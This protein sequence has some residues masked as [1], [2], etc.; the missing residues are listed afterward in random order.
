MIVF[1]HG[2]LQFPQR[3][4]RPEPDRKWWESCEKRARGDRMLSDA[5]IVKSRENGYSHSAGEKENCRTSDARELEQQKSLSLS[6]FLRVPEPSPPL[7]GAGTPPL[8][9]PR[10]CS[11]NRDVLALE[12]RVRVLHH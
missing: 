4:S 8:T 11:S 3:S 10:L 9:S 5:L 1:F 7:I 2:R 12:L 6:I